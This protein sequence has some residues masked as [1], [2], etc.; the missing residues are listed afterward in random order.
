MEEEKTGV[1]RPRLTFLRAIDEHSLETWIGPKRRVSGKSDL[2]NNKKKSLTYV[3]RRQ[4]T[5]RVPPTRLE[6]VTYGLE[7]RC[8]IH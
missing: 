1:L 7:G 5:S 8:S 6:R 2:T 4:E 3:C